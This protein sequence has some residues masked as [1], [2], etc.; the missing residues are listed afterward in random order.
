MKTTKILALIALAAIAAACAKENEAPENE[1]PEEQAPVIPAEPGVIVFTAQAPTRTAIDSNDEVVSWVAGDEVRFSWEGGYAIATA[2]SAGA[3]TTFSVEITEGVDEIYA[4][5][6]ASAGGS[7]NDGKVTVHYSGSRADGTFAANDISV[8][9]AVKTGDEWDTSLAFKNA[10]CL[11]KVGVTRS[12]ITKLRVE[13]VGGEEIAGAFEVSMDGDGNPVAG[14]A[15]GTPGSM[16][17]MTVSGP[18]NYYI[19]VKPGVTL[20]NGFRVSRFIGDEQTTP[21]YYNGEFTTTRGKI[22]KLN[23]IDAHAGHYYVTPEG[24]GT[25]SGQSWSNAMDAAT[26]KTFIENNEGNNFFII[27]GSTFHF[28]AEEFSFG[29]DYVKPSFSGHNAVAFT[30]EGTVTATDTTTFLGRTATSGTTAGVLWPQAS[31]YVTVKNVK[32]TG[33]NGASNASAIR[34]NNSV[35]ELTLDHCYFRNNKTAGNGGSI[36]LFNSATVTIK[37]CSFSGNTGAG[38][39]IHVNNASAKVYIQD[40]EVKE[41]SKNAIYSQNCSTLTATRVTFKDNEDAG[42]IG[43][44]AFVEGSGNVTFE[45]C[46]FSR[47]HSTKFGGAI[48]VYGAAPTVSFNDCDFIDNSADKGGGAAYIYNGNASTSFTGG[49]FQG[50]YATGVSNTESAGAAIYAT[51]SGVVF[52]CT[53]VLF[54]SNYNAVGSNEYSGGVIRVEQD[55]GIARLNGCVFDGN[56]TYRS[57]SANAACAAVVNSRTKEPIYYFNAC[58]FKNNASGTYAGTG[59]KYGMLMAMYTAGTIAM[60]NCSVHDNYGGRNTDALDWIY[61]DNA[62][63]KLIIT[64]SSIIGEATR[65]TGANATPGRPTPSGTYI[66]AAVYLSNPGECYFINNIMCSPNTDSYSIK[67]TDRTITKAYYNKTSPVQGTCS[68][69]DDTGSGHDY[70]ASSSCFGS[71]SAPY[72]WNGTLTGTNSNM[73]AATADVNTEIQNADADFYAWLNS[74]GALGKDIAGNSRGATSWPGCYQN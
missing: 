2:S 50:N 73:K 13:A 20:S 68:W 24:A 63:S 31:T 14:D 19:P 26:F 7:V 45:D 55:G 29:D 46:E 67:A 60:N 58:E 56:Y 35:K 8:A 65:K 74:I 66:G 10:A 37:D 3:S 12:D 33:T 22:I 64:N 15:V 17:A 70:Y 32:F 4:I 1:A 41:C 34:L 38:G 49:K 6:P 69:T 59:A 39:M 9:R 72:S 48:A 30:L 51:G 11:L 61:I 27:N 43:A 42:E 23:D 21:F 57:S 18:G 52:N 25:K 53:D 5:Y 47:N 40:C 28:S 62:N 36:S 44:A 16:S 71:W 54:K